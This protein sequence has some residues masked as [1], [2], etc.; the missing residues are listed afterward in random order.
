M[1]KCFY[2]IA[3]WE[4][5]IEVWRERKNC[6]KRALDIKNWIGL[7]TDFEISFFIMGEGKNP[8]VN[9]HAWHWG[10]DTEG[11]NAAR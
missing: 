10:T 3:G 9:I 7:G 5:K 6:H 2:K 11:A 1:L 4:G 8:G